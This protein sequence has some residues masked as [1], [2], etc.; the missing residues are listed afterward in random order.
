LERTEPGSVP[1]LPTTPAIAKPSQPVVYWIVGLSLCLG[2]IGN[3]I[4]RVTPW[5]I[6]ASMFVGL[7]GGGIAWGWRRHKE[8]TPCWD[9]LILVGVFGLCLAWRDAP[10]LFRL[11]LLTIIA[12]L[13]VLST[14]PTHR[15]L[16]TGTLN[17]LL[18]N[19]THGAGQSLC[20]PVL[21]FVRDI[22]WT[23]ARLPLGS[24]HRR[25]LRAL[26]LAFP[27]LVVFICL[28]SAADAVF[29]HGIT[30]IVN[31]PS[32]LFMHSHEHILFSLL[33]FIMATMALRPIT[34]RENFK[35]YHTTPPDTCVPGKIELSVVMGSILVLFL[36]FILVQFRYLFGGHNTVH[37][38]SGLTYAT[39]ARRGFF[40]LL[41]VVALVHLILMIGAWLV[42]H[43]HSGTQA[44]F[45]WL[46]L[47]LI[48]LTSL[49]FASAIFRLSI[50]IKT[51]GLT[52]LRF[53]A[54]AILVWLGLVL[55]LSLIKCL[56]PGWSFFTGAYLYSL[57]GI[58]LLINLLNPDAYIARINLDRFLAQNKLDR[59]YMEGLS[60]DAIPVIMRYQGQLGQEDLNSLL[61]QIMANRST[62]KADWRCWNYS[63]AKARETCKH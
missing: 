18:A 36:A 19:A 34:L 5:G 43:A 60:T 7:L 2:I 11:N 13:V 24:T 8:S 15:Q 39:Y 14:R 61:T 52:Q 58:L 40:A 55:L 53:Y 1:H 29:Q 12:L 54:V 27:F 31:L 51:Y 23:L 46:S 44:L 28:F 38:I 50:Y 22:D 3:G 47:G 21:L 10:I 63:R 62:H 33:F 16:Y 26:I 48:L 9:L 37:S 30:T 35:P 49:V 41:A 32:D 20:S 42:Q 45:R 4:L 17:S 57:L 25:I 56:F 6:N 59:S